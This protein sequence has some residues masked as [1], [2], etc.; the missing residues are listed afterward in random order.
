MSVPSIAPAA[1]LGDRVHDLVDGELALDEERAARRH[2]ASCVECRDEFVRLSR[3]VSLLHAQGRVLAPVGFTPRVVK[4][5][6]SLNRRRTR[7]ALA[8]KVP[9]EGVVILLIA[10]AAATAVIGWQVVTRPPV[11]APVSEHSESAR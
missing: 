9:F 8:Y 7:L 11:D 4:R 10:A 1:H 5:A 6:R 3:T 2:L